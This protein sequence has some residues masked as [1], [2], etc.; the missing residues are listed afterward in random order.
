MD[1][2]ERYLTIINTI[3]EKNNISKEELKEI[4]KEKEMKYMI[5]LCLEK[6]D[7]LDEEN[8]K[9]VLR[10]KTKKSIYNNLRKAE[11][12][13]LINHKFRKKYFELEKNIENIIEI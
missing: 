2:H 4:L 6:Y 11:E 10:I 3:C 1:N 12:K 7:C 8:F 9:D 5:I 13:L